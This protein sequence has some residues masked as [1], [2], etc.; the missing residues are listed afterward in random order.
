[1]NLIHII[2][3]GG[4]IA[5]RTD[6]NGL[7]V[8]ACSGEE[9]LLAIPELRDSAIRTEQLCNIASAHLTSE[10]W[11]NTR[12]AIITACADPEV[13]GLVLVQGTDS[14][15]ETAFFMDA[16]LSHADTL[17]KSIVLTGAMLNAD[18]P[19]SDGPTNLLNA[20]RIAGQAP[21]NSPVLATLLG[22]IHCARAVQK[23]HSTDVH[24]FASVHHPR[25]GQIDTTGH[26][27]WIAADRWTR[28]PTA[29]PSLDCAHLPKVAIIP[30]F[31]GADAD[32]FNASIAAGAQAIV[33][34]ALGAGN[35][36]PI[37]YTAI[38]S[39]I[40]RDIP[41]IIATRSWEGCAEPHYGYIGGGQTLAK[42]GVCFAHDLPAH[43]ARIWAQLLLCQMDS[44]TTAAR[45]THLRDGFK[46]LIHSVTAS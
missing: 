15:E 35:V 27:D 42:I 14:L 17:G 30:T 33:V 25:I 4:T 1:M 3:T 10:I 39:A 36:N 45:T 23:F 26:I 37:L 20:I 46:Q 32:L 24:A 6:P 41:V 8:P 16:S 7:L 9:L 40:Q 19:Q 34:Q 38:E 13:A 44:G 43:K 5:M 18:N 28:T 31:V 11:L 29:A 2:F 12:R 21:K 22:E